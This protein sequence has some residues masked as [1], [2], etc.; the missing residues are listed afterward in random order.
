[1]AGW[2]NVPAFSEEITRRIGIFEKRLERTLARSGRSRR[3][4]T[5]VAVS[6]THGAETVAAAASAGLVHFGENYAQE[7]AAKQRVLSGVPLHF[8]FIGPLQTN[9]V[10]MVVGGCHLLHTVD[11]LRLAEAVSSRATAL[12][13]VQDILFEVHLSPEE[14]KSGV[15]PEALRELVERTLALPGL[16][17]LGLMTMPPWSDDPEESRPCFARLARLCSDLSSELSLPGFRHLSMGMSH[18]FEVAVE[19]GATL[20]RV[21]TALFGDRP[22]K[23]P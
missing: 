8:H 21:G 15:A 19:E 4:V 1:M 12:G 6:K 22:G 13:I 11:R 18:D 5:L 23:V 17:P 20:I 9:K 3:D 2:W 16:R 14:S 7:M 10:K